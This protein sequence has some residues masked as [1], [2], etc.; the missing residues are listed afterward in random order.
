VDD[1]RQARSRFPPWEKAALVTVYILPL[2]ALQA[3]LLLRCHW[4]HS[5][6]RYWCCLCGSRAWRG[7]CKP[8]GAKRTFRHEVIPATRLAEALPM[9][10]KRREDG[11]AWRG[12]SVNERLMAHYGSLLMPE[13]ARLSAEDSRATARPL[14]GGDQHSHRSVGYRSMS[15]IDSERDQATPPAAQEAFEQAHGAPRGEP[16]R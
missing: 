16:A 14:P 6:A 8:A 13:P 4:L 5:P 1:P 11:T 12:D 3:G 9:D 2:F 10:T 15:I 7:A